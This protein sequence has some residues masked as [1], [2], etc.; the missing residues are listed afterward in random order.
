MRFRGVE[1]RPHKL[2]RF[3]PAAPTLDISGP[4]RAEGGTEVPVPGSSTVTGNPFMN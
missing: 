2:A 4:H 3:R 1:F